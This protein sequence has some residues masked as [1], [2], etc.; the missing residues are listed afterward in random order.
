M[1]YDSEVS[2]KYLAWVIR[3][4][5]SFKSM[6]GDIRKVAVAEYTERSTNEVN[7]H[8]AIYTVGKSKSIYR[9]FM[10]LPSG[11]ISELSTTRFNIFA[12]DED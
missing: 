4:A 6:N 1:P 12:G 11:A 2:E 9:H 5:H 3:K 8:V 7:T 10:R